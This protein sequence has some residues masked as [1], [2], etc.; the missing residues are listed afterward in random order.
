MAKKRKEGFSI[1]KELCLVDVDDPDSL[2]SDAK[3]E[4]Q[5]MYA[6]WDA[7]RPLK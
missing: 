2:V 1:E 3:A 5:R 6:L 7:V 4:M